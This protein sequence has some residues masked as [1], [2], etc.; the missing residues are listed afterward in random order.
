MQHSPR[1]NE[2][3]PLRE[4]KRQDLSTTLLPLPQLPTAPRM[5]AV[6]PHWHLLHRP[7]I[8][9]FP[10]QQQRKIK[11]WTKISLLD[12]ARALLRVCFPWPWDL[13]L[14]TA[15]DSTDNPSVTMFLHHDSLLSKQSIRASNQP[16]V[17]NCQS[18]TAD[19]KALSGRY[20]RV[21]N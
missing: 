17:H 20:S 4:I 13:R 5:A 1:R 10:P 6:R 12:M 15:R 21:Q 8:T 3:R 16:F 11:R 9:K 7:A 14:D 19:K 18:K 2:N